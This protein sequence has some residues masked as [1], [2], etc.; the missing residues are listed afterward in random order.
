[1]S[2]H[3]NFKR[4]MN[5]ALRLALAAQQEPQLLFAPEYYARYRE[6][7]ISDV[8]DF[9]APVLVRLEPDQRT[10]RLGM[11]IRSQGPLYL[12][13]DFGVAALDWMRMWKTWYVDYLA[14]VYDSLADAMSGNG[15]EIALDP[16]RLQD[17]HRSA[18][19]DAQ[20]FPKLFILAYSEPWTFAGHSVDSGMVARAEKL[21]RG[22]AVAVPSA[23]SSWTRK[24]WDVKF[25]EVSGAEWAD[26]C[27]RGFREEWPQLLRAA[28][29]RIRASA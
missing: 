24:V 15:G 1:M 29:S 11:W 9:V 2:D 28:A 14:P 5:K 20:L 18:H 27:W 12:R 13:D 23:V 26:V 10:F 22:E 4:L 3:T 8:R 21:L 7:V 25:A 16:P 17:I 6:S 19:S